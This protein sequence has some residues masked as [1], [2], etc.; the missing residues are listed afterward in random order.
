LTEKEVLQNA[1]DAARKAARAGR[2]FAGLLDDYAKYLMQPSWRGRAQESYRSA[3]NKLTV[4]NEGLATCD[5]LIVESAEAAASDSAQ[6]EALK[7]SEAEGK[8]Q[9]EAS[10][11][12][13]NAEKPIRRPIRIAKKAVGK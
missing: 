8:S 5:K 1:A 13:G 9:G 12:K 6:Q 7:Q 11:K 2:E 3:L 4:I 10:L